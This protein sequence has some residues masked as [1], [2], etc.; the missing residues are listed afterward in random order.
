MANTVQIMGLGGSLRAA[1]TSRTALW[2]RYRPRRRPGLTPVSSGSAT[3]R[4]GGLR[5]AVRVFPAWDDVACPH[6]NGGP[7]RR[8]STKIIR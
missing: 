6:G 7:V 3:L 1:E 2:S 5:Q 4:A 8:V